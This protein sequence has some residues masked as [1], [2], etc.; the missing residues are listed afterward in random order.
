MLCKVHILDAPYHLDRPFDYSSEDTV[1]CGDLVR[2]PFGKSNSTRLGI[3][4]SVSDEPAGEGI[5]P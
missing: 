1:R 5:K 4:I 2:V 3:V